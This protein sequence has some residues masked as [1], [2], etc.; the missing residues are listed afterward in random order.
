LP[1][2][3]EIEEASF[4]DPWLAEVIAH[5]IRRKDTTGLVAIVNEEVAGYAIY[6]LVQEDGDAVL[7]V[8]RLAVAE[9]CRFCGVGGVLLDDLI[10]RLTLVRDKMVFPVRES[11]LIAQVWLREYG[12]QC[13]EIRD[14][15]FGDG[16]SAYVFTRYFGGEV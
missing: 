12:L 6:Q 8:A 10:G 3:R 7:R 2:V 14:D 1:D 13:E 4:G 16:E 15:W 9:W 11:N 5:S